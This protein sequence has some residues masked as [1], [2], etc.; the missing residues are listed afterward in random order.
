[1][2]L[3][4]IAAFAVPRLFTIADKTT[5]RALSEAVEELKGHISQYY[6]LQ[7]SKGATA[8]D[9]DCSS[10]TINTDLGSNYTP[11]ITSNQRMTS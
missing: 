4:T 1:M 3:G 5:D 6:N 10:I 7:L 9:I 8:S 2:V 11:T